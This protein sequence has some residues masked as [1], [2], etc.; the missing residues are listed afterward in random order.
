[1]TDFELA[2]KNMVDCQIRPSSVVNPVLL[3]SFEDIPREIFVPEKLQHIAY[4][5]E[6]IDIGQG[7]FLMEPATH[8]KLLQEANLKENDIVL[9][10]GVGSGYSSAILSSNVSTVISLEVNKRQMDKATRLWSELDL[11][12][13]ALVESSL[14]NGE[15]KH[16]PY[17]LIVINGAVPEVPQIILDQLADNGRLV[18]IIKSPKQTIGKATIFAKDSHG[19]ISSEPLFEAGVPYIKGF[20]TKTSFQF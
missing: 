17:S 5:D 9:D 19:H 4:S 7:R 10:V 20:D 16:A 8:A 13:I 2:R 3:K 15:S 14:N 1:M 11:C 18:T 6:N 12:N